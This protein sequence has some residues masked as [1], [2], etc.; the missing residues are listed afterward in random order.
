MEHLGKPEGYNRRQ[1]EGWTKRYFAA[2]TH[3][4]QELEECIAWLN[5]KIP[6]ESRSAIVHN[7]YKFDNVM[8]DPNDLTRITAV[9]D[10]EMVTIG[11]PLM[12]LGTT[13]GYWMSSEVG[14]EML[15]MPFN[16]RVLMENISRQQLAEMYAECSGQELPDMLFY[17][18]FGTFKIAVIAQQIYARYAKGFTKDERFARFDRFVSALGEIA[19][20]ALERG[21]V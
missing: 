9:L 10:W 20:H 7:D 21:A 12:D 2:K 17:Y 19:S 8:L 18:V 5:G 1:V 14:D 6:T 16:P 15:S 11:D 3:E 4:W 13:L